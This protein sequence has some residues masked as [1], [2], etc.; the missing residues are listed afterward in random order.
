MVMNKKTD[1]S[2]KCQ[3]TYKYQFDEF[4]NLVD[5]NGAPC[6]K[7]QVDIARKN[8]STIQGYDK[9]NKQERKEMI[10]FIRQYKELL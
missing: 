9:G 7:T 2:T 8:P 4:Y 1:T 5:V 6:N 10:N 3:T